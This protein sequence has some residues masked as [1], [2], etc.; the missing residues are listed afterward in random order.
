MT[1]G[2]SAE[3]ALPPALRRLL[4]LH[5]RGFWRRTFRKARTPRGLVLTLAGAVIVIL[6]LLPMVLG[7][8]MSRRLPADPME[9]AQWLPLAVLALL[10]VTA[11]TALG[12]RPLTFTAAETDVLFPGPFTR[13]QLLLYRIARTSLAS[14][15]GT[16]LVALAMGRQT[17]GVLSSLP[18]FLVLLLFL[19]AAATAVTLTGQLLSARCGAVWQR[20]ALLA[21][22][23]LLFAMALATVPLPPP[24]QTPEAAV[25]WVVDRLRALRDSPVMAVAL[26]PLKPLTL[27]LAPVDGLWK[28]AGL[29]TSLGLLAGLV[30]ACLKLDADFLEASA[31]AARRQ[32]AAMQKAMRTGVAYTVTTTRL[33]CP[34]LPR[35]GGVGAVAWYQLTTGLRAV[36]KLILL[37]ACASAGL[38][39][40]MVARTHADPAGPITALFVLLTLMGGGLF[41]FDF[42]SEIDR[43]DTLKLLPVRPT[44]MAAGQVLAPVTLISMLQM[45]LAALLVAW[46]P[47]AWSLALWMAAFGPLVALLLVGIENIAF[48]MLPSRARVVTPGDLAGLARSAVVF[49]AKMTTLAAAMGV[50]VLAGLLGHT[51]RH[52]RWRD[53][54][55]GG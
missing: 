19:Q 51:P 9:F 17:G 32:S 30:G 29:L 43:L 20:L 16:L 14:G 44:A 11:V 22:V 52:G 36:W 24:G 35:W 8:A 26:T 49:L 10:V 6:W 54:S 27:A 2:R 3:A 37:L 41:R 15:A 50:S 5:V 4:W 12:G 21:A 45:L 7:G 38:L 48:L 39:S 1:G 47:D 33:R 53:V 28:L 25:A 46:R 18:G 23:G 40:V 34:N 42:R 31:S 13:R 55:S